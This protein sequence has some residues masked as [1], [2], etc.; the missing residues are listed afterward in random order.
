MAGY[1]LIVVKSNDDIEKEKA[2]QEEINNY[3]PELYES[4]LSRH[5][6]QAWEMN[7]WA[8]EQH[9]TELLDCLRQRNG[10][11]DPETLKQIREQG[12]SEIY[13]MLSA[14]KIRAAVS[15]IRDILMP[16][17]DRP[18][19]LSPTPIPELPPFAMNAISQR[20]QQT[21]PA[22]EPDVGYEQYIEGRAG[23]MRDEA[24]R[25]M[26]I[27]A[28]ECS[29]KMEEKIADQLTEGNWDESLGEFIE[30]FCTF[31]AA[32]MKAPVIQKKKNLKW[33][34]Q[35]QPIVSDDI[36]L[37]YSR[38]SPFD[39]YPSPDS[40]TINDGD[41]IERIRYTRRGLY[42]MI[43]LPGYNAE[44]IRAVLSDYGRGG[45]RD[46][47]WR[48]YE[49][50]QLE[51]KD[52]F[53]MR[54][55]Q[56]T[57][58]GLQYW[59]SAQ[60]LWLLEWGINPDEIDDPLAEYEIDAIKVGTH[61]IRAVI[62]KDPLQRRPYHKA[63]FQMTPGSFWGIALPKLMRDHQRMCN[64]TARA[65][66]NNLGIASGPIVEVEV[67]RLA[68]GESV[69]QIFPW[70]IYQTKSD[71]TGRGREAIRFYQP[72]SNAQE[73]LRVYEEFE[74]RADD[75]TSI[76]RYAHGN[77]KVG[78]AGSTAA[79]LS[80]LMNNASKGIKMSIS[81]IDSGVVKP[82]IEHTFTYNMLYDKDMSIKG[83][84]NIVAR[85]ATAL[86]TKEQTQMRRAEFLNM[87][88]NEIDMSIMGVEGRLEVLRSA[89][90]LL[91]IE[92][93]T[94]IP[95]K[96]DFA[97]RQQEKQQ[98][99]PPPDP[100]IIEI[101]Q[102]GQ[103]EKEKQ[104]MEMQQ[105]QQKLEA[106]GG[107]TREKMD[108]ELEKFQRKLD[109]EYDL[110]VKLMEEESAQKELDRELERE[111]EEAAK[112]NDIERIKESVRLE[113]EAK[114]EAETNKVNSEPKQ[115]EAP[116]PVINLNIDNKTGNVTK[117]ID[118]KHGKD[119]RLTGATV[120]EVEE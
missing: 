40:S 27:T 96:E 66:A 30:D 14:T 25:A 57:I 11:Y 47:L 21:L 81:S 115:L 106:D 4:Q 2:A 13:M 118:L 1:G 50:A 112:E 116:G 23:K 45:L 100:K 69:E 91:D 97:L 24:M 5:I 18:W 64:A 58:D 33:G 107:M 60:G 77:E 76:P 43:G 102:K 87:T 52:K 94:V 34:P 83:D 89:A 53:W 113:R 78:G 98:Q 73:L 72:K 68:D 29:K 82:V 90:E 19:G 92:A 9:E 99:E 37:N 74:R 95:T 54:Q 7:R 103:I 12:G 20:I 119:K 105:F 15:W 38:V 44:A 108:L 16:A 8:K 3:S 62:N 59:G 70:K 117:T 101:Q 84:V 49:R 79:G 88:N 42:N 109:M 104:A 32:I 10:E 65:L 75:A 80:M 41:L 56:R 51:G 61:I 31:P 114:T 36:G 86:L 67:D 93:G 35:G 6:Q 46:W 120:T 26:R 17:G 63:S 110:K 48:D 71:K 85:G 39:I 111:K 28:K 55:D 22:M